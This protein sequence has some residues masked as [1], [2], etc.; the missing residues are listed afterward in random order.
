MQ[1]KFSLTVCKCVDAFSISLF[2]HFFSSLH[3]IHIR[4]KLTTASSRIQYFSAPSLRDVGHWLP[5]WQLRQRMLWRH[6]TG[7]TRVKLHVNGGSHGIVLSVSQ[8][9]VDRLIIIISWWW[10]TQSRCVAASAMIAT[11]AC[12]C[13]WCIASYHTHNRP[14]HRRLTVQA[15]N[16]F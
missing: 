8:T 15:D 7:G 11:D 4:H 14:Q 1:V 9:T 16:M 3:T 2:L 12:M 6:G 10:L 13:H 5:A